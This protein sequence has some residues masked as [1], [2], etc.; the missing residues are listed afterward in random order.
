MDYQ[1]P[2]SGG[3]H[4]C[5]DSQIALVPKTSRGCAIDPSTC[6]R[7]C[8]TQSTSDQAVNCLGIRLGWDRRISRYPAGVAI[9]YYVDRL[10]FPTP[11][12]AEYAARCF[13]EA[14]WAWGTIPVG[15]I[16]VLAKED[17]FFSIIFSRQPPNGTTTIIAFFPNDP[18]EK[19]T[20]TIYPFAFAPVNRDALA[21]ML[22]HELGHVLGL[23]H[24]FAAEKEL[25]EP[26]RLWGDPNP[27]SVMNYY[28]NPFEFAVHPLD[29]KLL[30]TFYNDDRQDLDGFPIDI[31]WP[32]V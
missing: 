20:I 1:D 7:F 12:N 18:P 25:H 22:C 14:T 24:E 13:E 30:K 28:T 2:D 17:A 9:P 10:I 11:E 8:Q 6:T 3:H 29:I 27:E 5:N 23:R 4:G 15:F 32:L 16:R 19:R 31:V 26:S 21:N